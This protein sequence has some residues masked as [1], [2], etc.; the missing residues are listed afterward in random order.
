LQIYEIK[1]QLLLLDVIDFLI[2]KG[3]INIWIYASSK[4]FFLPLINLLKIKDIPEVQ[5]KLLYLIKKWGIKFEEQKNIIS[6]FS[7]IYNRLK[8]GGVEFPNYNGL[9]YNIYIKNVKDEKKSINDNDS[10]YYLEKLKN[11]LKEENFQHKYRRLVAFLLKMNENVKLANNYIDSKNTEKL[12]EVIKILKD[13]HK[14]LIDTITGGRLKDENLMEF[15]LGTSEDINNT[16]LREEE[17]NNGSSEIP[18]F[19]SYFEKNNTIPKKINNI[20]NNQNDYSIDENFGKVYME[21]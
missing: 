16:L 12:S 9:D 21:N 7:D 5:I 19:I 3:N 10:F 6:N 4:K 18:K 13:G 11:I 8:N 17:L 14:T 15:S 1:K 2:D 20:E